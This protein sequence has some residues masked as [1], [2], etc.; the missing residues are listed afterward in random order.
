MRLALLVFLGC[1]TSEKPSVVGPPDGSPRADAVV[2]DAAVPDASPPPEEHA[3]VLDDRGLVE[4][5]IP[6]GQVTRLGGKG[7]TDCGMDP[8]SKVVWL[9]GSGSLEAYDLVEQ[10][11]HVIV[12]WKEEGPD[13][14]VALVG[15]KRYGTN[16]PFFSVGLLVDVAKQELSVE[17][18]CDG[19]GHWL[20]Y[21]DDG[22]TPRE[23]HTAKLAAAEKLRLA[24]RAY[25]KTLAARSAPVAVFV[26]PALPVTGKPPAVDP[27]G[28]EDDPEVCGKVYPI[29]G[30]SFAEIVLGNARGDFYH[31]F[32]GLWSPG[33]GKKIFYFAEGK[34]HAAK[35]PPR[36]LDGMESVGDLWVSPRG[37]LSVGGHVLAG[38]EVVFRP[39]GR[40]T[41]CGWREGGLRTRD[42][43]D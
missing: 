2:V 5:A 20:C 26:P 10:K 4:V 23:E 34:L 3:F 25:L 16:N 22:E 31:E 12:R 1:Q 17:A 24:D 19:D 37:A 7:A 9:A 30:T 33:L 8:Q 42:L 11:P 40:G 43:E 29:P 36:E 14:A 39:K 6:S 27:A 38:T 28:C 18:G 35:A 21:D 13:S 32:R 41:S 15:D